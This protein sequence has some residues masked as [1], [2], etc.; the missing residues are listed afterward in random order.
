[1]P[2]TNTELPEL[3]PGIE[4]VEGI[5]RVGPQVRIDAETV[6]CLRRF[7]RS[8]TAA[9][10][11]RVQIGVD[12][13]PPSPSIVRAM[14]EALFDPRRVLAVALVHEAGGFRGKMVRGILAV[15]GS[16]RSKLGGPPVRVFERL[17]SA[18]A[19]LEGQFVA[20]G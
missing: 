17:E 5:V 15:V 6:E 13:A 18:Q 16:G 8:E 3:P 11:V 20:P 7:V 1:M 9:V 10:A 19:W 14:D 2:M 4:L 12:T